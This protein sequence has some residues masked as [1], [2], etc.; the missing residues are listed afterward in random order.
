MEIFFFFLRRKKII[1][2]F[3]KN[4]C[5]ALK[6]TDH[7]P[8]S[9]LVM[10]LRG[11]TVSQSMRNGM[12][13]RILAPYPFLWLRLKMNSGWHP[14]ST[15]RPSYCHFVL[16]LLNHWSVWRKKRSKFRVCIRISNYTEKCAKF[17][18]R[19]IKLTVVTFITKPEIIY[20]LDLEGYHVFFFNPTRYFCSL[21][22]VAVVF[23]LSQKEMHKSEKKPGKN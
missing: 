15:L 21:D 18:F 17:F 2:I 7:I 16:N 1:I 22:V 5:Q 4:V 6:L 23:F 14:S 9:F 3:I 8:F 13:F 10:A 11:K 12:Q 19:Q 20:L